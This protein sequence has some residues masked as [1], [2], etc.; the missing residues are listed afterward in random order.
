M[1]SVLSNMRKKRVSQGTDQVVKK[2]S[3]QG[4]LQQLLRSKSA[5]RNAILVREIIDRPDHLW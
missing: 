4:L 3:R 2:S 5:L 1:T